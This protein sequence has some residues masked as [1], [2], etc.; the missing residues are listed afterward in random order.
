[1]PGR[2]DLDER[3]LQAMNDPAVLAAIAKAN[4][5]SPVNLKVREIRQLLDFL[6]ALTDPAMLDLR[7]DVPRSLPSG[8]PLAD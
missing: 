2:S 1:M 3:D 8:L 5:L 6:N 4:E 7:G